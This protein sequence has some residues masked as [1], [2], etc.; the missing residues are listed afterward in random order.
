MT[1]AATEHHQP[2]L[3]PEAMHRILLATVDRQGGDYRVLTYYATVAPLGETVR[4]TAR[5]IAGYLGL[6][7]GS[8]G[9]AV[10]RLARDGWLELAFTI[11]GVNQYRVGP[12]LMEYCTR[13][14]DSLHPRETTRMRTALAS[15]HHLPTRRAGSE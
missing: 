4:Q 14:A 5:E 11:A 10:K 6:H 12:R 2:Q 1:S 13:P 7:E 3:T 9:K 8:V 15:V